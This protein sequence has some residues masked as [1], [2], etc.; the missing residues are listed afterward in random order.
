[1]LLEVVK[2]ADYVLECLPRHQK[3]MVGKGE[4]SMCV[5]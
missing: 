2:P 4:V 1:M 3:C 5:G